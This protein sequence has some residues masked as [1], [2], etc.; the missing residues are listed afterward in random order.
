MGGVLG[1]VPVFQGLGEC[2]FALCVGL[3]SPCVGMGPA[4]GRVTCRTERLLS[5]HE[6]VAA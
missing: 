3:A 4:E 6:G 2:R 5:V 1:D